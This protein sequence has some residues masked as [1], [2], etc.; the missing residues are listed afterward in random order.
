M[1]KPKDWVPDDKLTDI[2]MN[3]IE[4][5]VANAQSYIQ[6]PSDKTLEMKMSTRDGHLVLN[7]EEVK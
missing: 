2:E 4:Q 5:G 1:Y 3:R 7:V 6:T